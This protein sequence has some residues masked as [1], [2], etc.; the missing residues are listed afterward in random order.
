MV[1]AVCQRNKSTGKPVPTKKNTTKTKDG[2]MPL[3]TITY[4]SDFTGLSSQSIALVSLKNMFGLPYDFEHKFACDKVKACKTLINSVNKPGILYDD[5]IG[6]IHDD[7]PAVDFYQYTCPCQGLSGFGKQD[8][9]DSRTTLVS[10]AILFVRKKKPKCFVSEQVHQW[11]AKGKFKALHDWVVAEHIK[12]GYEIHEKSVNSK[13]YGV[14]QQRVRHYLVGIRKDIARTRAASIDI[15]PNKEHYPSKLPV[16]FIAPRLP[17]ALWKPHPPTGTPQ[18]DNVMAAYSKCKV[19]PFVVP[20]IVDA[21]SSPGKFQDFAVASC[22]TLAAARAS[23]RGYWCSTKG[24]Y[25]D[26]H[27]MS[28]LQGYHPI[29][30]TALPDAGVSNAQLGHCLG[31]AQSANYLLLLY[32]RVLFHAQLI[33]LVEYKNVM[34]SLDLRFLNLDKAGKPEDEFTFGYSARSSSTSSSSS[35]RVQLG[36]APS[37]T[38]ASS[39][40]SAGPP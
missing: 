2:G 21:G 36:G 12:D 24:G 35:S 10:Y 25:L 15:F 29:L 6:R 28:S 22:P 11:G 9:G 14:P 33:T 3:K 31:N 16:Q 26:V 30:G 18:Y 32:P 27:E 38:V 8:L 39:A 13:D 34:A 5:V 20:V 1:K 40:P 23:Q 17:T 4:G 37:A 19:N 7:V